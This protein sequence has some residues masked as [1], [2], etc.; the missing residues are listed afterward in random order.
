MRALAK[1][2]TIG[3]WSV[4]DL[5]EQPRNEA[6]NVSAGARPRSATEVRGTS[7]SADST[8]PDEQAKAGSFPGVRRPA[9]GSYSSIV[10][11]GPAGGKSESL[12]DPVC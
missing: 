3:A 11:K 8:E 2:V 7:W 12:F 4:D 1:R 9:S 10:V 5:Y 6:D